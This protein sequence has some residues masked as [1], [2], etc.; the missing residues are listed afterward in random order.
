MTENTPTA[1]P[2]P[3]LGRAQ[4]ITGLIA[5]GALALAGLYTLRDFLPSIAWAVVIAI[6]IWPAF[7]RLRSRWPRHRRLLLPAAIVVAILLLIALPLLAIIGPAFQDG[8]AAMRWIEQSRIVGL[9][10]P[11]FLHQLPY[12]AQLTEFWR[13]NLGQPGAISALAGA[14]HARVLELG[15][16]FG[17]A[18]A[19]RLATVGFMLLVLFFLLRDADSVT[20]QLRVAGLRTIGPAGE[21]VALQAIRA[22][23]GTVNGLVLVGLAEGFILGIAYW[24]AGAP[25]PALLG[26]MTAILAMVPFG[27]GVAVAIAALALLIAGKL[28]AAVAILTFGLLVTFLADHFAR[29]ALIGGATRLPFVWV[30]LGFLGGF[31]TWGLVGLFIGPALLSVLV[32]L[33][34][35]YV[36]RD[37]GA[38]EAAP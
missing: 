4:R 19:R 21:R 15:R 23:Q 14:S 11:A 30:L 31:E 33:W 37:G 26:L 34:R 36:G 17:A 16:H 29:P 9:A 20:G 27:A 28:F 6:G 7:Q 12:G 5:V 25:H 38:A 10:P 24:I 35:E 22:V 13:N 1:P 18:A 8:R 2:E 3:P 32:L